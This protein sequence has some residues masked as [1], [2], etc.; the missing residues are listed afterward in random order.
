MFDHF[1]Y[2]VHISAGGLEIFRHFPGVTI[3]SFTVGKAHSGN[4]LLALLDVTQYANSLS[5]R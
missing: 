2:A 3:K 4:N 1:D 5:F